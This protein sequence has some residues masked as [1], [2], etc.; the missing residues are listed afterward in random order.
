MSKL[1]PVKGGLEDKIRR[2]VATKDFASVGWFDSDGLH[3]TAGMTYP[4]LAEYHATG[5]EGVTPRDVLGVAADLFD[6][7]DYQSIKQSISTYLQIGSADAA[8][9]IVEAIGEAFWLECHDTIGTSRL[10]ITNNPTP[11]VDTSDLKDHLSYNTNKDP[12]LK[13]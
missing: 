4:D 7:K 9:G 5:R 11:L 6:A 2:L 1:T 12:T 8:N 13:R 10:P 3:E